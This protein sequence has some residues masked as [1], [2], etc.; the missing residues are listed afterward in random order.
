MYCPFLEGDGLGSI[1]TD[2]ELRRFGSSGA[3]PC[4]TSW[5]PSPAMALA[6]PRYASGEDHDR[7]NWWRSSTGQAVPY[8]GCSGTLTIAVRPIMSKLIPFVTPSPP[9]LVPHER[10]SITRYWIFFCGLKSNC[11]FCKTSYVFFNFYIS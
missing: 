9:K 7:R 2:S 10:Y 5:P 11:P 1:T 6:R 4:D 3:S 8:K